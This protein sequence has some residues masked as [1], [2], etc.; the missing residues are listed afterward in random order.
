MTK[1]RDERI[2]LGAIIGAQGIRGEV[3]IRSFTQTPEDIGDYCPLTDS[4]GGTSFELK[5]LRL[6]KKG[7]IARVKGVNDR[8]G[9]EA[10]KGTE[11]YALSLL[12]PEP[13]SGEFYYCD[14]IGLDAVD[15]DGVNIGAVVSVQNFGAGDLVEIRLQG[16]ETT[17]FLPFNDECVVEVSLKEERIVV[18]VPEGLWD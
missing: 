3:I 2:C 10:L 17:E 12:L 16:A 13:E 18:A 9:A 5:V 8:N 7:V 4:D 15:S 14:L 11:L 6:S 1:D